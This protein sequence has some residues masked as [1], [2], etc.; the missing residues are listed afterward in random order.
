MTA[1][2]SEFSIFCVRAEG[3][4][5]MA[6]YASKHASQSLP[7]SHFCVY[8]ALRNLTWKLQVICGSLA[9][10]TMAILSETFFEWFRVELEIQ[11]ESY[12][13]RQASVVFWY[14]IVRVYCKSVYTSLFDTQLR[15][16]TKFPHL[17]T[18]YMYYTPNGGFSAIDASFYANKVG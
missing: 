7:I 3:K 17:M 16:T 10:W 4:I 14:D 1:L 12:G 5:W 15:L 18:A 11:L 6:R 9:Y 8:S 13:P 2:L